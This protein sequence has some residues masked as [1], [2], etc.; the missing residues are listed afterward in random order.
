[1][2]N[3]ASPDMNKLELFVNSAVSTYSVVFDNTDW[4]KME[5]LLASQHNTH[6]SK[7]N[8]SFPLTT[9]IAAVLAIAVLG[10]IIYQLSRKGVSPDIEPPPAVTPLETKPEPVKPPVKSKLDEIVPEKDDSATEQEQLPAKDTTAV[11]KSG[12]ETNT[13]APAT[14][15]NN[16]SAAD[17]KPAP[18]TTTSGSTVTN[19][20]SQPSTTP[21]ANNTSNNTS[22]N[23]ATTGYKKPSAALTALYNYNRK[24]K[25]QKDSIQ[26]IMLQGKTIG[27]EIKQPDN[28][29]MKPVEHPK[30]KGN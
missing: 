12:N 7:K 8:G 26:Q 1:M 6:K 18:V 10:V 16:T 5:Q 4:E 28:L 3:V 14:V 20:K 24:K 27:S 23:N 11:Y 22:T 19:N 17:E 30:L 15:K 21:G 2:S 25:R 29:Q 9:V 13:T